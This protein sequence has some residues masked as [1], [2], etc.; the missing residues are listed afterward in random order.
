MSEAEIA[1]ARRDWE[2]G[3]RRLLEETRD[4]TARERVHAQVES[5][6]DELRRRV[7]STFT[8]AEL[9]REYARAESWSRFVVGESAAG[10]GWPRLLALVEAAA[11][12]L[13]ARG[14]TDYDP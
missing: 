7:G 1:S 2:D 8:L 3:H 6:L 10:P 4:H 9:A 13:S 11:F 5:V 12:H 14:A